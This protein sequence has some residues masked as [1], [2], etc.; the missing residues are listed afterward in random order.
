MQEKNSIFDNFK[1]DSVE[2]AEE[3]KEGTEEPIVKT[4]GEAEP[5]KKETP[6]EKKEE[7]K[8]ENVEEIPKKE[9][10]LKGQSHQKKKE[11]GP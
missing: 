2:Y 4:D 7:I 11:G 5:E 10:L 3:K 1:L 6:I 9:E 8:K